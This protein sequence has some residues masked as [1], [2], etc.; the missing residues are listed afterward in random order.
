VKLL[1]RT[2]ESLFIFEVVKKFA[3]I[4]LLFIYG[5][6]TVGATIHLHYC[7]NEFVGWSLIPD[8][9]KTCGKCGMQ[10]NDKGGCCKDEHRHFQLKTD[11]QKSNV[12]QLSEL[13]FLPVL[14]P[15]DNSFGP[16]TS[17][18][19][20]DQFPLCHAPPGAGQIPLHVLNRTLLI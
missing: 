12:L 1:K 5:T 4:L 16:C 7:M 10:E 15:A 19:V 20:S 2:F 3:V 11:H 14:L 9:N 17:T 6:S 13:V 8:G 18:V